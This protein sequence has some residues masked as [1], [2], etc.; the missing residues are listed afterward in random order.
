M[1]RFPRIFRFY[2]TETDKTSKEKKMEKDLKVLTKKHSNVLNSA[3]QIFAIA[4][5]CL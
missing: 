4:I 2:D 5:N 3:R 1:D